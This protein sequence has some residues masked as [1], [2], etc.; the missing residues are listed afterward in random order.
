[1]FGNGVKTAVGGGMK[2]R[3]A[4]TALILFEVFAILVGV[5]GAGAAF[6]YWRLESGPVSLNI[7]RPSAEIAI[8]RRLPV[9]YDVTIDDVVLRRA[10]DRSDVIVSI[11]DLHIQNTEREETASAED[12]SLTFDLGDMLSGEFGAKLIN[13]SGAK[14][15]IVRN[16]NLNIELP[17]V[18]RQRK[19]SFFSAISPVF[20]KQILKSAFKA[21]EVENAEITFVDSAS[22]RSWVAPAASVTLKRNQDGLIGALDGVIDMGASTAALSATAHYVDASG[23][24]SVVADG[25]NFPV[26][27][28]LTTFYGEQASILDAPVTGKAVISFSTSGDVLASS[29]SASVGEGELRI[30]DGAIPIT[31]LEWETQFDPARNA[32]AVDRFAFDAGGSTGAVTGSVE[33]AFG[34]DIRSPESVV[35]DLSSE[36]MVIAAEGFLPEP[37]AVPFLSLTGG[38]QVQERRLS[39]G[40]IQ[41]RFQEMSVDGNLAIE[42]PVAEAEADSISP[43][44]SADLAFDGA[45]DPQRLMKV[46]PLGVAMGARDWIEDRVD[47]ATIENIRFQM[48]LA[49]GAVG[50]DQGLPDEAMALSF[51]VR[52]ARAYFIK[53]M[54]PVTG[55]GSGIVRGN[56]FSFSVP[57]ARVGEAV[58]T[59]GEVEFPIFIPKWQPTYIRFTAT[60]NSEVL[61]GVIDQQPLSLLSKTQLSPQ[62]FSGDAQAR[63][64]I[65]R[66][67]KRDAA[68][69]EYRYSGTATFENM[70]ITDLA[71]D[72]EL[73]N[74]NGAIGLES[75][76]DESHSGREIV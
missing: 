49:P 14:F 70:T 4:K 55:S 51:D 62:Q 12:I 19:N 64:E 11:S 30:G 38:Y 63:I 40:V 57:N 72:V 26:G 42:F 6:L 23:L 37:L 75:A 76:V 61:L 34:E 47:R 20:D 65:M 56:S 35:F 2:K 10:G 59:D 46:W 27:D 3:A 25:S 60:G 5:A 33:V 73:S 68:P 7:F 17:A 22:G 32:F 9:G 43:G 39:L 8:K 45:M 67:N 48:D 24:V 74:A 52:D 1:M 66:P 44:I 58:I 50:E 31:S 29:F 18:R 41:S 16:E 28:L 69:E 53:A 54:T 21:A 71:G 15:R 13:A 36:D